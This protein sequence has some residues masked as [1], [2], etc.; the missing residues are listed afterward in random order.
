MN[1]L[2]STWVLLATGLVFAF[3]MIYSRVK[4]HTELKDEILY[5]YFI[6][7]IVAKLICPS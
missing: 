6:C 5:V 4:D 3:P 1:M 2:I 7:Y